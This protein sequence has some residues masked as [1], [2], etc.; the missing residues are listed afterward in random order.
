MM[1]SNIKFIKR[2]T[3]KLDLRIK[4]FCNQLTYCR[5]FL[6]SQLAVA[7]A[8]F[9]PSADLSIGSSSVRADG[10]RRGV[11]EDGGPAASDWAS[12]GPLTSCGG[13][14]GPRSWRQQRS[15][16]LAATALGAGGG[17]GPRSWRRRPSELAAA[18]A[19]GACSGGDGLSG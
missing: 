11:A 16:E 8:A 5:R 17:G 2:A 13:G 1:Y 3:S 6:P 9:S 14:D 12:G 15:S 18:A 7:A 4:I 19:L 10:P